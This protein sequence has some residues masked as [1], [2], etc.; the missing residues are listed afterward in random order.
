[1]E[2]TPSNQTVFNRKRSSPLSVITPTPDN[3]V[4]NP[5]PKGMPNR[6][7]TLQGGEDEMTIASTGQKQIASNLPEIGNSSS[8]RRLPPIANQSTDEYAPPSGRRIREPEK[9]MPVQA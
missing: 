6:L 1:M 3:N 8:R 5:M 9:R 4:A 7:S 2:Y